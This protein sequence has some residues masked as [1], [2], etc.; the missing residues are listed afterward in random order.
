MTKHLAHNV[1]PL[2]G[3]ISVK[4]CSA[5]YMIELVSTV[6]LAVTELLVELR[7]LLSIRTKRFTISLNAVACLKFSTF[8]R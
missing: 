3:R 2:E 6:L 8:C 4:F 5:P 7:R 1:M